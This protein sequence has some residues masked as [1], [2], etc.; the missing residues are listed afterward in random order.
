RRSADLRVLG[1]AGATRGNHWNM[2]GAFDRRHELEVESTVRA[3]SIDTVE[4][5]FPGAK[6][7]ADSGEGHRVDGTPF[8]ASAYRAFV[9]AVALASRT[10]K[11]SLDDV[12]RNCIG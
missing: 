7:L 10:G 8:S 2:H 11:R 6:L 4:E 1:T 3:I 5:N 9:P 12:M